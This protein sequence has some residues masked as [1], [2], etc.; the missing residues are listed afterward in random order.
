MKRFFM[1]LMICLLPLTLVRGEDFLLKEA[2]K[3]FKPIPFGPPELKD[4]PLTLEKIELGKMLFFDPRLSSNQFI[5]CNSCHNLA[6]GGADY[7]ERAIGHKWQRG[8]RNSPTV[9]NA[10]FN[11]AQ[12]WDGSA[13]NLKEQAEEPIQAEDEMN[14]TPERVI[15]TFKSIPGYV[16]MFKKAFP[17]DKDP[18]TFD[19]ITKAIEAFEAT[20]LTPNCKLDKFL[21]GDT[22]ALNRK[23]KKGLELFIKKGCVKCHN[24]INIGGNAFYP[25]GVEKKPSGKI[26][27]GDIGRAKITHSKKDKFVFRSPSLRNVELTAPYFHSGSVWSLKEAVKI[28][29]NSQI[30]KEISDQEAELIVDFL[31]TLTGVNPKITLPVLPPSTDKTPKPMQN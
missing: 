19:N 17:M 21:R 4:N 20:L 2:R 11:V 23:E 15:K 3:H 27:K 30:G 1:I 8:T 26:L 29:G 18:I 6:M 31:K 10:V 13:K 22:S 28:M 24:G 16:A 9:F 7:Q 25:F 12:N 14:N 5:S